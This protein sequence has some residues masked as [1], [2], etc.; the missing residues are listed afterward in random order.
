MAC[1]DD[2]MNTGRRRCKCGHCCCPSAIIG[3]TGPTGATGATGIG[4]TGATGPTGPTGATGTC[5]CHCR[6]TG[7]LVNNGG[8]EEIVNNKPTAWTFIN[9]AG[10]KSEAEQG[11]V[12]SGSASVNLT[13]RSAIEQTIAIEEGCFYEF[14]FFARGEGAQVCIEA[15][16]TFVTPTQDIDAG[17]INIRCQDLTNDNRD[18]AYFRI[19]TIAAPANATA[20]IIRITVSANGNQSADI[21]DVSFSVQ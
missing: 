19:L 10:V 6:A 4:T 8:M 2:L 1:N 12:H 20:A 13:D 21:D 14:S 15:S 5:Q 3:P 9:P 18:F 16:V 11:R 7:E 17:E